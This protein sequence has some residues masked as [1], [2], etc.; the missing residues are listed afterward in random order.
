MLLKLELLWVHFAWDRNQN[1]WRKFARCTEVSVPEYLAKRDPEPLQNHPRAHLLQVLQ[2]RQN[3]TWQTM[4]NK[5]KN[6]Y[7]FYRIWYEMDLL[8]WWLIGRVVPWSLGR[9]DYKTI[10]VELSAGW[11]QLLQHTI[12]VKSVD[13]ISRYVRLLTTYVKW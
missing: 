4:A 5:A 11:P 3:E 6:F 1:L 13:I 9:N 7:R 2:P 8:Y 10:W 12:G